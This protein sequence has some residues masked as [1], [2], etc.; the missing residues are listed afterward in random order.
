MSDRMKAVGVGIRGRPAQARNP[1]FRQLLDKA[2]ASSQA[3]RE[4]ALESLKAQQV[5]ARQSLL[6]QVDALAEAMAQSLL[7]Q[8]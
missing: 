6:S 8:A 4:A 2:R 1:R 5:E 3:E 7:K